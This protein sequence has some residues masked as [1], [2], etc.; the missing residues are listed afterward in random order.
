MV[1]LHFVV[2]RTASAGKNLT[3]PP[4]LIWIPLALAIGVVG[5]AVTALPGWHGLGKVLVLEGVVAAL[6]MGLGAVM[7]PLIT[8]A[9]P[10]TAANTRAP[11][12]AHLVGVALFVISFALQSQTWLPPRLGYA[13]RLG[14]AL[15]VLVGGAQLWKWPTLPGLNRR[16]VLIAAWGLPLGYGLLTLWPEQRSLGLHVVFLGG[17]G[18]LALTVGQHV[19]VSHSGRA[20]WLAAWPATTW[21]MALL[22][23][24]AIFAR[25]AMQLDPTRYL[26]WMTVAAVAFIGAGACWLWG[27]APVLLGRTGSIE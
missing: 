27:M 11:L 13:I 3:A 9:E 6:V 20:D 2:S 10:T 14:L 16:L 17:F 4:S 22:T 23:A 25:A 19:V 21:A 5:A 12:W 24:A 8:R 26:N 7:V 18:L 1:L 15:L